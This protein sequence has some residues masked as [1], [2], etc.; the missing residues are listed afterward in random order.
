[1]SKNARTKLFKSLV[2]KSITNIDPAVSVINQDSIE[3]IFAATFE[4]LMIGWGGRKHR[5]GRG[6][7]GL[8]S[9]MR[10]D[11]KLWKITCVFAEM[12]P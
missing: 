5:L 2:R 11:Q 12:D 1:M 7:E 4:N 8:R 3:N 6:E 9:R 10:W